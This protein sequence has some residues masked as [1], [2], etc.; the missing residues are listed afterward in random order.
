MGIGRIRVALLHP[1]LSFIFIT[2]VA[3]R[4]SNTLLCKIEPSLAQHVF[5]RLSIF[6]AM[7]CYRM[8]ASLWVYNRCLLGSSG[9]RVAPLLI[10]FAWCLM[11]NGRIR[12]VLLHLQ[13]PPIFLEPLATLLHAY[14]IFDK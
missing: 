4:H 1:H 2:H 7:H 14:F 9:I 6:A 3:T 13:I 5:T 10:C 12:V 11:E 8:H